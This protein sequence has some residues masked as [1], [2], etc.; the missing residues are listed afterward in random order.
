MPKKVLEMTLDVKLATELETD[1]QKEFSKFLEVQM[2]EP[3]HLLPKAD[4]STIVALNTALQAII[5]IEPIIEEHPFYYQGL[6]SFSGI[7][8]DVLHTLEQREK[9][10]T[11]EAIPAEVVEDEK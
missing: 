1:E 5:N 11:S 10:K 4:V 9:D 8:S 6:S 3:T 2:G 7:L